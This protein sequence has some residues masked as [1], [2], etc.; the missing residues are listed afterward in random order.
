MCSFFND[1]FWNHN[2]FYFHNPTS[3]ENLLALLRYFSMD[4]ILGRERKINGLTEKFT[5]KPNNISVKQARRYTTIQL[6]IIR[7]GDGLSILKALPDTD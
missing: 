7:T 2:Y 4:I 1:A 3:I 5:N 6:D